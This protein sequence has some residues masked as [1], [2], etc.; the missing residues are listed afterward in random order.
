MWQIVKEIH[1][2]KLEANV[3]TDQWPNFT[4]VVSQEFTPKLS[5]VGKF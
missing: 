5:Q 4:T 2:K 1:E 3:Y